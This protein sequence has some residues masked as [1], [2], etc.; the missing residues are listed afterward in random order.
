MD[1]KYKTGLKALAT[2]AGLLLVLAAVAVLTGWRPRGVLVFGGPS[3]GG[4]PFAEAEAQLFAKLLNHAWWERKPTRADVE[5]IVQAL[6]K[7][8]AFHL[9]VFDRR[10]NLIPDAVLNEERRLVGW[11]LDGVPPGPERERNLR[12]QAAKDKGRCQ[13]R[14]DDAQGRFLTRA[15]ALAMLAAALDRRVFNPTAYPY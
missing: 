15:E 1:A 13:L 9:I 4:D 5:A 7:A 14:I 3:P 10:G 12:E 6:T 8:G 2:V 11:G